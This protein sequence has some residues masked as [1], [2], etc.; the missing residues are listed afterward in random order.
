V[1]HG[2]VWHGSLGRLVRSGI[3]AGGTFFRSAVRWRERLI[4]PLK[5]AATPPTARNSGPFPREP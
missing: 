2:L 4:P 3:R 1:R 5:F